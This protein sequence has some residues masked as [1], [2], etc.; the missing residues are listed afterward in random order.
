MGQS[1]PFISVIVPV[2]NDPTGIQTTLSSLIEQ[3]Y[4]QPAH[5][6][7]IV[8]NGSTD[9]TTNIIQQFSNKYDHISLIVEDSVQS[10]YAARNTGI[11]ASNSEILAFLDSDM[12]VESDWLDHLYNQMN[13]KEVRYL[14]CNVKQYIADDQVSKVAL[15]DS[16]TGFPVESYVKKQQYSPTCCLCVHRSVFDEVG[17][18]DTRLI[19]GGDLEFGNRVAAADINLHYTSEITV[20]HPARTTLMS[21]FAKEIRV[22]SGLC[23]KQRYYPNRY[24]KPGIPPRPSGVK[25]PTE[26]DPSISPIDYMYIYILSYITI[27]I[28]GIGYYAEFIR[29]LSSRLTETI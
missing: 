3:T 8:D 11:Q 14:A 4:P 27:L 21:L 29:I 24:G 17:L 16:I 26:I 15:Y 19:S 10:S 28:R 23:Q 9:K 20:Y 6:I 12:S 7:L 22:G 2:Y 18:F 25:S 1:T 13:G 5:E